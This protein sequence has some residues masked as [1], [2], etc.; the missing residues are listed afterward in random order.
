MELAKPK[1]EPNQRTQYVRL[2]LLGRH[3]GKDRVSAGECL[4]HEASGLLGVAGKER[5]EPLEALPLLLF[6]QDGTE[7]G[8]QIPLRLLELQPAWAQL[9]LTD[10]RQDHAKDKDPHGEHQERG[11]QVDL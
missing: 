1:D 6:Q 2:P 4:F 3:A 7:L 9:D 5:C 10:E 8:V 11:A